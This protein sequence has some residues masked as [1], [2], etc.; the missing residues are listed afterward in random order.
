MYLSLNWLKD[1]VN[2]P[3]SITPEEL[4]LRLTMHTVEIDGVE[5]QADN[6][7]IWCG[8]SFA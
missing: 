8:C 1:F 7:R 6:S 5:K 4:G 3:K 2:I